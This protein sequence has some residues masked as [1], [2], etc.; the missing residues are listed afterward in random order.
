MT[1][2]STR[3]QCAP[4]NAALRAMFAARKRVF[5]DLLKWDL[6]ILAGEYE[7]DQFDT[8]DAFY[9]ILLDDDGKHR[10]SARLLPSEK[11]HL[12]GDLY[13]HLCD[14][15]VPRGPAIRE[16]SRF[17]LDRD[18]DAASRLAARN[19]LV[20]ALAH[21]AVREG[22][23]GYTGI[24]EEGWF[25]Q[26]AA[27]GWRCEALGGPVEDHGTRLTALHIAIDD[28]TLGGLES[29]G[30]YA[31]LAFRLAETGEILA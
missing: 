11:P 24:A 5:I 16:I 7:L 15:A 12:L 14:G 3:A 19:Q 2:L 22:I 26:I 28:Q 8:P 17:C 18:Q 6:P 20:T 21:H 10:A 1:D 23:S 9:L 13:S 4:G 25:M 31:P 30:V 27:F 29:T